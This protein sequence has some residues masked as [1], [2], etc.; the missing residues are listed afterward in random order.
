MNR[1]C[2]NQIF[3]ERRVHAAN[4]AQ[5][6]LA[7][8]LQIEFSWQM[9]ATSKLQIVCTTKKLK[10][11]SIRRTNKLQHNCL[12]MAPFI[13]DCRP[14]GRLATAAAWE[15]SCGKLLR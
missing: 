4:V 7:K 14:L 2:F 11:Q 13:S 3:M 6:D 10:L 9:E 8:Q 15:A 5:I 1:N 12:M